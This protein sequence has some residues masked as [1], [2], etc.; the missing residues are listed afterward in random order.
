MTSNQIAYWQLQNDKRNTAIKEGE[1]EEKI[2]HNKV[3]EDTEN[4]KAQSQ[5]LKNSASAT[6]DLV[7]AVTGLGKY[8]G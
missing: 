1:L 2:R 6:K 3:S 5:H 7:S 8:F 4:F